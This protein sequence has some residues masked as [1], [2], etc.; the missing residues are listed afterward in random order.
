M[1]RSRLQWPRLTRKNLSMN[2]LFQTRLVLISFLCIASC[3]HPIHAAV[4]PVA[5]ELTPIPPAPER[6]DP[7][8]M[9][10]LM[11]DKRRVVN[12]FYCGIFMPIFDGRSYS[13]EAFID[14]FVIRR[15][16]R[17]WILKIEQA[18]LQKLFEEFRASV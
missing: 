2:S 13:I 4:P 8:G 12:C 15:S 1:L 10:I 7:L 16:F 3:F 5:L 14:N 11:E 18:I 17:N 9:A 6:L